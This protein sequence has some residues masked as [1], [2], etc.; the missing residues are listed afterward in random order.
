MIFYVAIAEW[1]EEDRKFAKIGKIDQIW[2]NFNE[3]FMEQN[4]NKDIS[5]SRAF[6]DK[7]GMKFRNSEKYQ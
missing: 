4:Q 7:Y 1:I 3:L 2:N 6:F 5:L